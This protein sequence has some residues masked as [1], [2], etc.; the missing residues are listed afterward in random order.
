MCAGV[1]QF[2][3]GAPQ[4]EGQTSHQFAFFGGGI[5]VEDDRFLSELDNQRALDDQK[6]IDN[7]I[8]RRD[9]RQKL[10]A[11]ASSMI[12]LWS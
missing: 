6:E 7:V 12:F 2:A 11:I 9:E 4:H 5:G 1:E 8:M 3:R 10:G